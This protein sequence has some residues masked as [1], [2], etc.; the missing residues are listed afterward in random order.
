MRHGIV[1]AVAAGLFTLLA[2][3]VGIASTVEAPEINQRTRCPV[4]GMFVAKYPAWIT[5][6]RYQNGEV[7]SFDGVKDMMAYYFDPQSFGNSVEGQIISIL[8]KDYYRQ[9]WIDGKKAFFV[10]GSDVYGPMGH[11]LIPFD[12]KDAAESFMKD[13]K[14]EELLLFSEITHEL[15]DSMRHGHQM[16]GNKKK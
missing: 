7:H 2:L 12:S 16:K 5:H 11:E 13:H 9:E 6:I 1:L 15:I 10:R 14:G 4:C 3:G 8:V